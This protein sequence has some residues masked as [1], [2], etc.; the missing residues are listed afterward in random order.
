MLGVVIRAS[1]DGTGIPVTEVGTWSEAL[2]HAARD[3]EAVVVVAPAA[4]IGL[5]DEYAGALLANPRLRI[6]T[7]TAS[8]EHASVFE[9]RILGVDVGCQ[10]VAHAI[11]TAIGAP[12][13]D[14][15]RTA[16]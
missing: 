1:L 12:A 5:S 10:D 15:I 7:V 6:L 3:S 8:Q 4:S 11:R 14:I 13:P 9:L 2:E 16:S